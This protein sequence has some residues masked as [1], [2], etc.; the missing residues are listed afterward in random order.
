MILKMKKIF[1]PVSALL[2]L[3]MFTFSQ[4]WTLLITTNTPAA[5]TLST[6]IYNPLNNSMIMF[7]GKLN[8]GNVLNEVWSLN[9]TSNVW[10]NITPSTGPMPT[11]RFTHNAMYDS[12]MNRM[13]IWSGQGA[14][15]YN[16]VWAFNLSN[17]TWHQLWMDGNMSG[18]PEKRY[19]TAAIFDPVKRRIINFAGFTAG[20]R[21]SDTWYFHVDSL[22]WRDMS[23]AVHPSGR[24]LH[25]AAYDAVQRRMIVY[26]GF[27]DSTLHDDIWALNPDTFTWT[28][29][30][31]AIRPAG[32]YFVSEII[33]KNRNVLVFGGNT[34][35]GTTNEMWRYSLIN[36]TWDSVSQGVSRPMPRFGQSTMYIPSQEKM[37][38]FGG[39]DNNNFLGDIWVFNN[40][41]AIG[42]KNISN[43]IPESFSLSQNYPNPFN[44]GTKIKFDIPVGNAYMRSVQLTIYDV[45][46]KEVATLI[47]QQLR[48]G[49][50]EV[51][52]SAANFPSGIYFYKLVVGENTNN[53]G[54]NVTKKMLLVK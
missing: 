18:V 14:E 23:N 7:G 16:D 50:Y 38:I 41:G 22:L 46:G 54:F 28:D 48:P 34:A 51:E 45:L 32:R 15:N 39:G 42:I 47:N 13:L 6:S 17:N 53:G 21:F 37:F 40:I 52:W 2:F 25:N 35:Q 12:V 29:I 24:C 20:Q 3:T 36:N 27:S 10:T 49:S 33:T 11:A 9:L 5:R 44:P 8:N 31:P 19:G 30:T 4:S 43:K 26:A 1:I